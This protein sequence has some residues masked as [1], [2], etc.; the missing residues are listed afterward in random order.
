[1]RTSIR[2]LTFFSP[3]KNS[4]PLSLINFGR[5]TSHINWTQEAEGVVMGTFRRYYNGSMLRDQVDNCN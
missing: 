1:M 2:R 5:T 3:R 4:T